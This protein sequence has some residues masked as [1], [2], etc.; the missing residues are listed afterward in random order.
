MKIQVRPESPEDDPWDSIPA[1]S[2]ARG[3]SPPEPYSRFGP[4]PPKKPTVNIGLGTTTVPLP[5][6]KPKK[7][8]RTAKEEL[9][10]KKRL[11]AEKIRAE[12]KVAKGDVHPDDAREE[13]LA[14]QELLMARKYE[15][16]LT[17]KRVREHLIEEEEAKVQVAEAWREEE[18]IAQ[19]EYERAMLAY[20]QDHLDQFGY[21]DDE[22]D[23]T[24]REYFEAQR[25]ARVD[26]EVLRKWKTEELL[27]MA[28]ESGPKLAEALA[29]LKRGHDGKIAPESLAAIQE[30]VREG[31]AAEAEGNL[32]V[33][34]STD[35]AAGS[36]ATQ[37]ILTGLMRVTDEHRQ[38]EKEDEADDA[39]FVARMRAEYPDSGDWNDDE[40]EPVP[41]IERPESLFSPLFSKYAATV[42]FKSHSEFNETVPAVK[43][44]QFVDQ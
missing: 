23:A 11:R 9:E 20:Q 41:G 29:A 1:P 18:R 2:P 37:E 24:V 26:E 3:G 17:M 25:R 6:D 35:I 36:N 16:E 12:K 21:Y 7:T 13:I 15:K 14:A 42:G 28:Q 38:M 31:V 32:R 10:L 5:A 44:L 33:V 34:N 19:E 8:P 30:A 40:M 43:R 39:A 27:A 4:S 22:G